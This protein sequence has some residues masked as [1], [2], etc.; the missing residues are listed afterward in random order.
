MSRRRGSCISVAPTAARDRAHPHPQAR[1]LRAIGRRLA[2][3]PVV[4]NTVH[5]LYATADDPGPGGAVYGLERLAAA[6]SHAELVQNAED[7]STLAP[8]G[9]P[10]DGSSARQRHRSGALRSRPDGSGGP[11]RI[12]ADLGAESRRRRGAVGRLVWEKGYGE[13]FVA[14]GELRGSCPEV[15]RRRRRTGRAG[16]A[17]HRGGGAGRRGTSGVR[18]LGHVR[19]RRLYAGGPA[20]VGVVP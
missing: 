6:C 4:I 18:F 17:R 13:V 20:R 14:A 5:G 9:V 3:V 19:R 12:R 8:L 11:M 15:N 16:G 1:Y 10:T 2:R 7:L